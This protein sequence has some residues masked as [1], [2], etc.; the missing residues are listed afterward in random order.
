M[1]VE[2]EIYRRQFSANLL[3]EVALLLRSSEDLECESRWL[4]KADE[5]AKLKYN[6]ALDKVLSN[7]CNFIGASDSDQAPHRHAGAHL[8]L[9]T[10][11]HQSVHVD[12][13]KSSSNVICVYGFMNNATQKEVKRESSCSSLS[14]CF[15][16][17]PILRLRCFEPLSKIP[18]EIGQSGFDMESVTCALH[19]VMTLVPHLSTSDLEQLY[20]IAP[21][22]GS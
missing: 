17:H 21:G 14:S 22:V 3:S 19:L 18:T 1:K 11:C 12:Q 4:D 2:S 10:L 13:S 8:A 15:K 9:T 5:S 6:S 16:V 7:L 20:S